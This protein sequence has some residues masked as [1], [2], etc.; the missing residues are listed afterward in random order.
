MISKKVGIYKIRNIIND[1]VYI[2]QST[3]ISR[4]LKHHFKVAAINP[5]DLEYKTPL[6]EAIRKYGEQSFEVSILEE[7]FKQ[8][9][10][11]REQFWISMYQ[12]FPPSLNKGYNLTAGGSNCSKT[13]QFLY[14]QLDNITKD[15][16]DADLKQIEIAKKYKTS[17]EMIQGINTGRYWFREAIKYPIR[18]FYIK[19]V[20]N[21]FGELERK[22]IKTRKKQI[23]LFCKICGEPITKLSST[24]LCK[25][26]SNNLKYR[27]IPEDFKE[28]V[29]QLKTKRAIGEYYKVGPIVIN[30]WLCEA[31]INLK[32]LN[33]KEDLRNHHKK[34]ACFLNI[35]DISPIAIY[36]SFAEASRSVGV[37][38]PINI[39][40]A[41]E[42]ST[43]YHNYYW[44]FLEQ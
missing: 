28:K 2:G 1:K 29:L 4:R 14:I 6:H 17:L 24:G 20:K 27:L 35:D 39:K 38:C 43:L 31:D 30:R 12:S 42:K 7:C 15:L 23:A 16:I 33:K 26:C 13:N 9:L 36:K 34:I 21:K 5:N 11:A 22:V 41:C 18:D 19:E 25:N 44:K 10:D 40:N 37:R 8:D 3:N 32:D